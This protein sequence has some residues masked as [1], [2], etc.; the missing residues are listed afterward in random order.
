METEEKLRILF[1]HW[2]E[3]N[4]AHEEE[5]ARWVQRAAEADLKEI[6]GEISAAAGCLQEATHHLR[7]ALSQLK[8]NPEGGRNVPE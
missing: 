4:A 5:F 8:E 7:L 2:I 3:H 1:E 6:S